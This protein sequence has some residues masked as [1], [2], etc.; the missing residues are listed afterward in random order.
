MPY[1]PALT[2][3]ARLFCIDFLE[4]FVKSSNHKILE[5]FNVIRID[6]FRI[7]CQLNNFLLTVSSNRYNAAACRC[8]ELFLL[9][10]FLLFFHLALHLLSLFHQVIHVSRHSAA[11]ATSFGHLFPPS[12][13]TLFKHSAR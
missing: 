6:N 11:E 1:L 13:K 4:H 10:G 12:A 7:N 5:R 2:V 8:L 3:N 9:Q